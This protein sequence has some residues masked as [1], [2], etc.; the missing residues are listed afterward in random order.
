MMIYVATCLQLI[1]VQSYNSYLS[2]F[3][4]GNAL[5][6]GKSIGHV[7]SGSTKTN[8]G[9]LKRTQRTWGSTWCNADSDGD[10]YT[11]GEEL[12]DPCCVWSS[13]NTPTFT[14][15]SYIAN[16]SSSSAIPSWQY[17]CGSDSSCTCSLDDLNLGASGISSSDCT[18]AQGHTD[19]CSFTKSGSTCDQLQCWHGLWVDPSSKAATNSVTCTVNTPAPT[20]ASPTP[21]PTPAPTPAP[22]PEPTP[23]PTPEPT[24][25]PT[26][27]SC[28]LSDITSIESGA[29]TTCGSSVQSGVN[30][31]FT[32]ASKSCNPAICTDGSWDTTTIACTSSSTPCDFNDINAPAGA[33]AASGSD[34][35]CVSGGVVQNLQVCILE[36][37]TS[38]CGAQTCNDGSWSPASPVCTDNPCNA[39][40]IP[41]PLG[42]T[43]TNCSGSSVTSGT[44]CGLSKTDARCSNSVCTAG[45]WSTPECTTICAWSSVSVPTGATVIA[46]AGGYVCS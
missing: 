19:T 31:A 3:P 23:A 45:S 42:A 24:P 18:G 9:N 38:T 27:A 21:E 37:S 4:N 8:F 32:H 36:T 20:P 11:N 41:T 22:T 29:T 12:G 35:N 5:G 33:T 13:G 39:A 15:S 14:G 40:L 16:P 34:S 28:A 46:N 7:N 17:C 25:S 1:A 26:P 43:V 30:C 44:A 2:D 10:G 6:I